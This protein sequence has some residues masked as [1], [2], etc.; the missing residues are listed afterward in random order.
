MK[1]P[2]AAD[3]PFNSYLKQHEPACLPG[4]H[5]SI[6]HEI[7]SWADGPD[8]RCIF[9][10]SGLPGTGK[11]TIARTVARSYHDRQRLAASFFFSLNTSDVS[12][13]GKFVTSIAVQLAHNVPASRQHICDAVAEHG[14]IAQQSLRDQW[15]HLVCHPLSKLL[16]PGP[17]IVIVDAL[18]EC[19][20][21]N[22]VRMIVQ[23]LADTRSLNRVRLRV[24]LTSRPEVPIRHGFGQMADSDHKDFVL[25]N[26][27]PSIA[28][29]AHDD[30]R[31][32]LEHALSIIAKEFGLNK[33]WPG[34]EAIRQLVQRASG[35]FVW[36]AIACRFIREGGRSADEKLHILITGSIP[37]DTASPEEQLDRMYITVLQTSI[38][39]I[40]DAHEK[41]RY[42][43]MLRLIL[44]SIVVLASP[45]SVNSL[46]ALLLL[47]KLK[48]DR[49]LKDLRAVLD[50]PK[51]ATRPLRLLHPS[52][53]DFLLSKDRCGDDSFWVDERS[54]HERLT[55]R[56]LELMSAA[57]GLR[58][59]MCSLFKPGILK[60][61]I[62]EELIGS[63]LPP[64]LQYACRYWVVHLE[65]SQQSIA[66]G[67]AVHVFL[68]THLLH[69]L[70][71]MSLMG[72]TG[73]CVRL[74]AGLQTLVTVRTSAQNTHLL[75]TNLRYSHQQAPVQASSAMQ[76][77]LYCVS[78]RSWH[79]HPYRYTRQR[80]SLHQRRALYGG[81]MLQRSHRRW[82][83]CQAGKQ[84]GMR[85]AACWR[86]TQTLSRRR[87]SRQ[88]YS[89][90]PQHPTTRQCDC[91]RRRRACVTEC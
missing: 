74:L 25:H 34:P 63:S 76:T 47:S 22:D 62:D 69:W 66:D 49:M 61:E 38:R 16:E 19:D 60:G 54:T 56:C 33:N 85:V 44:G 72:E 65:R 30:I 90:S 13:A 64:E 17:Y 57:N 41:T 18:D 70:E 84:T 78:A 6:L 68:Q 80:L 79:R 26:I 82:R 39:P 50:I 40:Y 20:D 8:E 36:A 3:A 21:D 35:L 5:V 59:D 43:S 71:A 86:A 75:H 23:L 55:S 27:S 87:C 73:Q 15:Q 37:G 4:T 53:C 9:W 58:Q 77:D 14:D 91:G 83:C 10:L 24:F 46:S 45:L 52:F 32:Y 51:D 12:N 1:L 67:N 48:V 89:W 42:Y 31:V 81:L 29:D 11:S 2:H 28:H 88:T 7:Y